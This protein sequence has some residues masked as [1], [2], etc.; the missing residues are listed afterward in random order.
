MSL[1]RT[2]FYQADVNALYSDEATVSYMLRAESALARAQA[3]HGLIPDWAADAIA[4]RCQS[5]LI[6]IDQL[7]DAI[8]LGANACI[9]LAKQLT[10][11]VEKQHPEAS[12]YVHFGATSQDII[13]TAT[14]SQTR[15]A[16]RLIQT[17]LRQLIAQLDALAVEHNQT[18][19]VGRT[20]LQQ[21]K[22]ITFGFK[23]RTWLDGL[24]RSAVR[25]ENLLV[26]TFALQL[27]GAVGDLKSMGAKGPAIAHTMADDLRLYNPPMAWHTQRDRI[28]DIAAVLGI[29]VGA[30]AKIATDIS[31][32]MQTEVGEVQEPAVAGKGGSSAMPHKRNPVSS[33]AIRAIAGRTPNLVATLFGCLVQDHERASGAWHAEWE[34]LAELVQLTAGAVHQA[35]IMTDGLVVN[36]ERM[37]QNIVATNG[38]LFA[39]NVVLALAPTI[40]KS[41]AT[42][43]LETACRESRQR[44]Q[45][46]QLYL[47]NQPLIQQHF[48][49]DEL[50]T[51]FDPTR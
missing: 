33:V 49:P 51:L 48:T 44:G 47:N 37:R 45:H 40:G 41:Q 36:A 29:L 2:L 3:Q 25:L 16:V 39:E 31:L 1:Y 50:A 28:A 35:I 23:V 19:M 22:P 32:M 14:M 15:D 20:L 38:L 17:D 6:D 43:F 46:L 12:A 24:G 34:P 8:P 30:V 4:D 21:A 11:L 7:V 42:A 26:E 10:A 27:G 5:Q 13:D 9:P 18:P